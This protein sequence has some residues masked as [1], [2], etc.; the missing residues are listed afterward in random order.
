[1]F[2][3]FCYIFIAIFRLN[4]IFDNAFVSYLLKRQKF[5]GVE[6]IINFMKNLSSYQFIL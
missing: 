4:M 6:K 5:N 1:M 3:K 2:I